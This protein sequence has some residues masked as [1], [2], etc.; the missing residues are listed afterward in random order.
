MRCI[1]WRATANWADARCHSEI[2][3]NRVSGTTSAPFESTAMISMYRVFIV[4][5]IMFGANLSSGAAPHADAARAQHP[6]RHRR[7]HV[8]GAH[9]HRRLQGRAHAEH[10]PRGPERRAVPQRLLCGAGLLTV[11]GGTADRPPCLDERGGE[12]ASR[13]V[14]GEVRQLS[15]SAGPRGIHRRL[16]RQAVVAGRT[17]AGPQGQSRRAGVQQSQAH[18]AALRHQGQRLHRELRRVPRRSGS[19]ARRSAS[20][21]AAW[22]RIAATSAAAG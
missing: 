1:R 3:A 4:L 2:G 14:P 17:R 20:G 22:S 9:V 7:R 12:H 18:A 10:R 16:H 6:H 13:V 5:F 8:V 21:M 11:A 19:R 15:R